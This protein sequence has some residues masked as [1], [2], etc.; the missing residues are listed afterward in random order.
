MNRPL[1][2][3]FSV[4]GVPVLVLTYMLILMLSISPFAFG[5]NQITDQRSMLLIIGVFVTTALI[6]AIGMALMKG[7]GF[8]KTWQM[9]DKQDRTGPYIMSGVFYLWLFKNLISGGQTPILFTAFVLG[10]T[11]SL[12][13][14]FFINIFTKVSAHAAGMG[15]ML[16]MLILLPFH[17]REAGDMVEIM[18]VGVS[19]PVIISLGLLLAGAVGAARLKLKAHTPADLY[20]GYLVGIFSVLLA[21]WFLD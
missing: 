21:V 15:G 14:C 13:L 20:R 19:W 18:G 16:M 11:I 9:D 4:I 2:H 7:L 12:F 10:A 6:P 17:W 8:V 5:A 3:F 1:A